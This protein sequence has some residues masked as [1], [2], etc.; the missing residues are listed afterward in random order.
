MNT[1]NVLSLFGAVAIAAAPLFSQTASA[2][3]KTF[4]DA[5][6]MRVHKQAWLL[7]LHNDAPMATVEG[8]DW[9]K[10]RTEGHT[11]LVRMKEGGMGGQFFVAYVSAD[12]VAKG[13]SAHRAL[14]MIDSIKHDIVGKN[15]NDYVLART[16]AELE[17]A[18]KGNKMAIVVAVEGGHAIEDSLRILRRF[19]DMG[20]RYMTLTHTNTNNWCD[21]QGDI[22]NP[23]IKHHNGLTDFGRDVIREMNRLGMMVDVSHISDKA[24]DDVLAVSQAPIIATHSSARVLSNHG[25][26]LTDDMMRQLATKGG[27]AGVNFS[28]DYLSQASNDS[29]PMKNPALRAKFMQAMA[30]VKDPKE[31]RATMR[32]LM[33]EAGAGMKRATIADVVA[34]IDHMVEI[35]GIDHVVIGSDFDGISCTPEGL[36]DTSKWPNLTRALLEKGYTALQI[37]KIY[38]T[39]LLNYMKRVE[40]AAAKLQKNS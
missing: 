30:E 16:A 18:R 25:R 19:Y 7:D 14:E 32:R 39:N 6:V 36:D 27:V 15:Q 29:S 8:L 13:T 35:M 1:Q 40:A 37:Q 12:H 23:A 5:E 38:S 24:F 17:A 4:T 2:P 10:R 26:N 3:K 21:S 28:C 31:R 20:A 33:A 9:S 11:D 22:D 34:N